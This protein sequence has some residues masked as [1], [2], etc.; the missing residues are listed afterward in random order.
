MGSRSWQQG[1]MLDCPRVT[2]SPIS[3]RPNHQGARRGR[4]QTQV[5]LVVRFRPRQEALC[6]GLTWWQQGGMLDCPRVTPSGGSRIDPIISLHDSQNFYQRSNKEWL[7]QG[8]ARQGPVPV[9]LSRSVFPS[10]QLGRPLTSRPTTSPPPP[11]FES[12]G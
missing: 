7:P 6:G 2:F 4:S 11:T 12:Q 10:P 5:L 9:N 8:A 1:G 3:P